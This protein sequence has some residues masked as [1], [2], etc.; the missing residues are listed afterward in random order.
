MLCHN[1]LYIKEALLLLLLL[2]LLLIYHRFYLLDV[3]A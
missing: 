3:G 1:L 2:L